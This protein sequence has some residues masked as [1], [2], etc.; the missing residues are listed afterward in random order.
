MV[1]IKSTAMI[2]IIIVV[3]AIIL[4]FIFEFFFGIKIGRGICK[5]VGG[6][7]LKAIYT[8]ALSGITEA[9]ISSAC[10]LLPF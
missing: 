7:L 8:G 9:G 1:V 6:I 5:L 2:L 3:L 10:N 4:F